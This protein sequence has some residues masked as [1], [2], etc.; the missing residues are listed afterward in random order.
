MQKKTSKTKRGIPIV[1]KIKNKKYYLSKYAFTNKTAATKTATMLRKNP[2]VK[3]VQI[4]TRI[5][6]N[7][8]VYLLYIRIA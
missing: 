7:K 1:K 4:Q 8:K 3:G 6:K 2:K 5:I